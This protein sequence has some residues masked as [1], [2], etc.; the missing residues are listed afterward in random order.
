MQAYR[1]GR[2]RTN[3]INKMH[4]EEKCDRMKKSP[5][6]D[7]YGTNSQLKTQKGNLKDNLSKSKRSSRS[8]SADKN[9]YLLKKVC[10]QSIFTKI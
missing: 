3:S 7:E 2:V 4:W 5:A 10:S 6:I 1:T 8:N 9:R